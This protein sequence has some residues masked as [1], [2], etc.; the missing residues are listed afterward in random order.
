MLLCTGIVYSPRSTALG[1]ARFSRVLNFIVIHLAV[2]L[3]N[4]A[5]QPGLN[6]FCILDV[7]PLS[8]YWQAY[9]YLQEG[10]VSPLPRS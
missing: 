7:W 9:L 6:K 10:L 8:E 4:K 3:V 1:P 2:I 5:N